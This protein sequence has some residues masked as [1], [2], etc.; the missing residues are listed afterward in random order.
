[1]V[2][3][4]G[5]RSSCKARSS[6]TS[7]GNGYQRASALAKRLPWSGKDD[8]EI[9]FMSSRRLRAS[10]RGFTSRPM[11][12][13]PRESIPRPGLECSRRFANHSSKEASVGLRAAL[14]PML[15]ALI[16]LSD[17]ELW[18]L[19]LLMS[20]SLYPRRRS[21]SCTSFGMS[22]GCPTRN[23]S[24]AV[25]VRSKSK[26]RV[27]STPAAASPSQRLCR[28]SR[29]SS[30]SADVPRRRPR[31]EQMRSLRRSLQY[32]GFHEDGVEGGAS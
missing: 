25:K 6:A 9:D 22:P 2:L 4:S 1:M 16:S 11:R 10:S 19:P 3:T 17:N 23:S 24:S 27:D 13:V 26:Q 7:S 12:A 21:A 32:C 28:P 5:R 31:C 30:R 15:S 20:P 8:L 14:K 18:A 29:R